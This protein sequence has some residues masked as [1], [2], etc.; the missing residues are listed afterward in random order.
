MSLEEMP[1]ENY[2]PGY[3]VIP[4]EVRNNNKLTPLDKLMY[5]E[6]L[7]SMTKDQDLLFESIRNAH[8]ITDQDIWNCIDNLI[9]QGYMVFDKKKSSYNLVNKIS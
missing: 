6:M 9:N 3:L 2:D 1:K 4:R 7:Q 8:N 5:G